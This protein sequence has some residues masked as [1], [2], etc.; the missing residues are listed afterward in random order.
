MFIF[1]CKF[2]WPGE[3][4]VFPAAVTKIKALDGV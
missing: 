4:D 3:V 2:T 1:L